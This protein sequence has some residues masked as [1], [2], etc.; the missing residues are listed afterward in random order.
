MRGR[1]QPA[2]YRRK[3]TQKTTLSPQVDILRPKQ[4]KLASMTRNLRLSS[5]CASF[6]HACLGSVFQHGSFFFKLGFGSGATRL[7]VHFWFSTQVFLCPI[8]TS[9]VPCL[10]L[11][12]LPPNTLQDAGNNWDSHETEDRPMRLVLQYQVA[13][14]FRSGASSR[15]FEVG[16]PHRFPLLPVDDVSVLRHSPLLKHEGSITLSHL[17]ECHDLQHAGRTLLCTFIGS[18]CCPCKLSTRRSKPF[19]SMPALS[20]RTLITAS[21]YLQI[22][23]MDMPEKLPLQVISSE[24][25][26]A[27]APGRHLHGWL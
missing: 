26:K 12:K 22:E 4:P 9:F 24:R 25:N 23:S 2:R 6:G 15:S 1:A 16:W 21:K 10:L 14:Q 5:S 7:D 20:L 8:H 3:L 11:S 13:A 18:N 19:K 17:V 27:D